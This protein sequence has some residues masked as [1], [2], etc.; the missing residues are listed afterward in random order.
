A[1][2]ATGEGLPMVALEAMGA[3][4]PVILSPGCYLPEVAECGAG[5]VVEPA[6]EPLS[7]ALTQLLTNPTQSRA[8]GR[9]GQQLIKNQFT[10]DAVALQLEKVYQSL[11]AVVG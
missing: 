1:L 6:C 2:P 7:A 4:L 9:Q 10:W 8:M 3:G 11:L 5:L